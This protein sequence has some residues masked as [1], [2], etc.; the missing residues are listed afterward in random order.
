[1]L[2]ARLHQRPAAKQGPRGEHQ[3]GGIALNVGAS[4]DRALAA[5]WAAVDVNTHGALGS[6]GL[7]AVLERLGVGLSSRGFRRVRAVSLC[8][9]IL[10]LS[11]IDRI[12]CCW[13]EVCMVEYAWVYD[14]TV[15][16]TALRAALPQGAQAHRRRR[17]GRAGRRAR[18]GRVR[19]PGLPRLVAPCALT[20]SR[21][22][23]CLLRS[24]LHTL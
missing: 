14:N 21:P 8:L 18:P 22:R 16:K 11:T 19:L 23:R 1:M 20:R 12:Y 3:H 10:L 9:S 6:E 24:A 4:D 2:L 13:M 7:R 5:A 15:R 17:P